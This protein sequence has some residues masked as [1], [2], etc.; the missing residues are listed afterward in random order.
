M[1]FLLSLGKGTKL[2]SVP[3]V[4]DSRYSTEHWHQLSHWIMPKFKDYFDKLIRCERGSVCRQ[5][6]HYTVLLS[7]IH[8][9]HSYT[10]LVSRPSKTDVPK[11]TDIKKSENS[12]SLSL[13]KVRSQCSKRSKD[14]E[15]CTITL[16]VNIL[17]AKLLICNLFNEGIRDS[18]V[19]AIKAQF[20]CLF[21]FLTWLVIMILT[22]YLSVNLSVKV[23]P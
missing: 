7:F 16:Y 20:S 5:I 22:F 21:Q 12:C 14:R 8:C 18:D 4:S 13:L 3:G 15:M 2:L 19:I 6:R 11:N 23:K 9:M 1:L 17:T 10:Y